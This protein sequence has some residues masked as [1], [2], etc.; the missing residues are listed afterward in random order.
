MKYDLSKF[1]ELVDQKYLRKSENE[2]LVLYKYTEKCTYEKYWNEYTRNARGII[3]EKKTGKL[4]AKP[5]PKFFNIGE[6]PETHITNLPNISYKVSEKVDGSLGIIY[7]YKGKWKVATNGSLNSEQSI[8]AEEL[9]KNYALS[10][11]LNH[12]TF[13]VEIIYPSNRIVIDYKGEEKLILLSA[14]R[15][16]DESEV[17]EL[18]MLSKWTKLPL[19]KSYNYSIEEM[20]KLQK[21]LPKDQEGFV[22][23]FENGLRAKIKGEE[24]CR[25]HKIVTNLSPLSFWEVMKDGKV[26][27]EYVQ[28]IPEEFNG[29]F[30]HMIKELE[31]SY[32]VIKKEVQEDF[33]SL[34]TKEQTPEARKEVGLYL[35]QYSFLHESAMFPMLMKKE[36]VIDSYIMKQIRPKGNTLQLL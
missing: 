21:T 31:K 5:F 26:P 14:Y 8:K 3:F 16:E 34:P 11:H 30:E 33:E 36:S 20:I 28:Q 1:E 32:I 22:I 24:Y 7:N 18:D 10:E 35:K 29:Q 25:I 15:T 9:L 23:R 13:L 12:Y 6:M 27:L 2:D 4:I 17:L 19:R